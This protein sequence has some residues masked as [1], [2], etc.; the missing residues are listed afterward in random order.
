MPSMS[1]ALLAAP[2]FFSRAIAMIGK[3]LMT[4][5]ITIT[6]MAI[7]MLECGPSAAWNS[8]GT[9]SRSVSND[10]NEMKIVAATRAAMF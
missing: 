3:A 7:A 9:D 5:E 6:P 2:R 4:R 1:W 10:V 8:L